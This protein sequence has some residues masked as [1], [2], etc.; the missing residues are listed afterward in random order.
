MTTSGEPPAEGHASKSVN[1]RRGMRRVFWLLSV[2]WWLG[3][4]VWLL[5]NVPAPPARQEFVSS[6]APSWQDRERR[7][8]CG[9]PQE[10]TTPYLALARPGANSADVERQARQVW[11]EGRNTHAACV[12]SVD[13]AIRREVAECRQEQESPVGQ[14]EVDERHRR[15]LFA[16]G[17]NLALASGALATV[18]FLIGLLAICLWKIGRWIR[19]GFRA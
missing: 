3:C 13:L 5:G 8:E 16:W 11:A 18:P 10:Y 9:Q 2:A 7:R 12:A 4:V 6:C 1:W 15:S 17:G 14:R 19:E